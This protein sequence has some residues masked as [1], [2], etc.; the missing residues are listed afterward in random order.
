V[1]RGATA[2]GPRLSVGS[3]RLGAALARG[4]VVRV[5]GAPKGKLTIV[6]RYGRRIVARGS[7]KIVAGGKGKATVR[8]TKAGRRAL[9]AKRRVTLK[10]TVGGATQ[11]VTLKR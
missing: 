7:A 4:L 6:A 2:K 9:R 8:F 5:T 3:V 11:T 1:P 10:L